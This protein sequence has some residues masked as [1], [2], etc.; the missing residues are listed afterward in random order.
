MKAAKFWQ[1][2]DSFYLFNRE[3]NCSRLALFLKSQNRIND[4]S[5]LCYTV[6]KYNFALYKLRDNA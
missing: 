1:I 4:N 5:P 3:I 2:I 6:E